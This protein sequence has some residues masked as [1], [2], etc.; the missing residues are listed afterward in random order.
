MSGAAVDSH[1]RSHDFA[2]RVRLETQLQ[3][4]I[5]NLVA[6]GLGIALVPDAMRRLQLPGAVFRPLTDSPRVEQ[7]VFWSGGNDNPCV[8]GFVESAGQLSRNP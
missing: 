2:P 7:G 5:I 1:C 6:E 3:Q 4:T 8:V